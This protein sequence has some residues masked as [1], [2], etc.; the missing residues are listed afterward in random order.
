ML[1]EEAI[2]LV[3][4]ACKCG[5][6]SHSFHQWGSGGSCC[7]FADLDTDISSSRSM[8]P[9]LG[10]YKRRQSLEGQAERPEA[11]VLDG[12]EGLRQA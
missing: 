5:R 9:R 3:W 4:K 1:S 11:C 6:Y 10:C 7:A 8:P 2:K 12:V